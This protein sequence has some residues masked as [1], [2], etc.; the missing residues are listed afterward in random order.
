M[1]FSVIFGKGQSGKDR[2]DRAGMVCHAG[3][4]IEGMFDV[5]GSTYPYA[6]V[7][8]WPDGVQMTFDKVRDAIHEHIYETS[9][10]G[11]PL[12]VLKETPRFHSWSKADSMVQSVLGE[13]DREMFF[14]AFKTL[15]DLDEK[16]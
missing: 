1:L 3:V 12:T 8:R 11:F 9:V 14:R 6:F 10:F 15:Q 13:L 2:V 7:E 16:T 5:N 4:L